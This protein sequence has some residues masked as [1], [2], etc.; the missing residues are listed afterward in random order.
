MDFSQHAYC[1]CR[2]DACVSDSL[3][4]KG[5]IERTAAIGRGFLN[6]SFLHDA[7]WGLFLHVRPKAALQAKGDVALTGL[8]HGLVVG[9]SLVCGWLMNLG[10]PSS[11]FLPGYLL[12]LFG[13]ASPHVHEPL[14]PKTAS[15][16][17]R[18]LVARVESIKLQRRAGWHTRI[19]VEFP[20]PNLAGRA[21]Q[22]R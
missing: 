2:P 9:M 18:T 16:H 1:V 11:F 4:S 3:G 17:T 13:H 15:W 8:A 7:M 22:G 12:A 21:T 5:D 6:F 14:A 19:I 10:W 20:L